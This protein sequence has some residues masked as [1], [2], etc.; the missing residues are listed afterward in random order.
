MSPLQRLRLPNELLAFVSHLPPT[1]K[2]KLRHALD[3]LLRDPNLGKPLRAELMG[4]WSLRVG[5]F[6]I[7]YRPQELVLEVIAIGPRSTSYSEV[8]ER[9]SRLRT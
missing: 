1:I 7:I 4:W 9:L 6:R 8:M 3:D 5:R 2:I